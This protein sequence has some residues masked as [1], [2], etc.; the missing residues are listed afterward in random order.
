[1]FEKYYLK[2]EEIDFTWDHLDMLWEDISILREIAGVI[3]RGGGS[4]AYVQGN[5]WDKTRQAVGEE[6]TKKFIKIFCRVNGLDFEET[7][8]LKDGMR[9]TVD[10][11][12]KVFDEA[13]KIGIKVDFEK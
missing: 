11:I 10:Q 5:P 1:M 9:I 6:K 2:W 12:E 7:H 8:E 4:M 3:R 13:R